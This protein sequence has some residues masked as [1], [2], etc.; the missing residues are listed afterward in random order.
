MPSM[1]TVHPIAVAISDVHLSHTPPPARSEEP[2]WY[3]AMRRPLKQVEYIARRNE[4]PIICA[5][6]L[7]HRW[8]S[9]PPLVNFA[10]KTCP[11]MFAIPG[12]HDLQYHQYNI[13]PT[14]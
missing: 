10:I 6:D 2:D 1:R 3:E 7:F 12:Q 14:K 4:V 8:W 9:P 13:P 5:G 11:K